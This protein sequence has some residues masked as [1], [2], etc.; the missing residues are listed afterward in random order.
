MNTLKNIEYI[1][2][3]SGTRFKDTGKK[4][5]LGDSVYY[6]DNEGNIETGEVFMMIDRARQDIIFYST[7]EGCEQTKKF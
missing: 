7:K 4:I 1:T 2:I 6:N 5:K 3:A